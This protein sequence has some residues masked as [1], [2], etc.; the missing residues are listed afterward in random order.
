[1]TAQPNV[2]NGGHANHA[3]AAVLSANTAPTTDSYL[4]MPST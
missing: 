4:M 1:M 3:L 2:T